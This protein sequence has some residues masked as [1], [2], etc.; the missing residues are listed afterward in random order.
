MRRVLFR[1]DAETDLIA[2]ALHVAEYSKE[3]A[4]ALL[5]RL[6]SRCEILHAHPFA[7]R[8]R[9]EFGADLRALVERPYVILYRIA[10]H[11]AEIVAILHGARDLPATLA[12]RL[13]SEES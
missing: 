2:I 10:E 4:A 1:P 13:N 6:R 7:G 5:A 9:P 3:R 12:A 11:D 8:P